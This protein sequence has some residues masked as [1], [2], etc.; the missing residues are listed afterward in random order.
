MVNSQK[1]T[2]GRFS[3]D[4]NKMSKKWRQDGQKVYKTKN[5]CSIFMI[6]VNYLD[7]I[8]TIIIPKFQTLVTSITGKLLYVIGKKKPVLH[9]DCGVSL[10]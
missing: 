9:G 4:L 7:N 1:C 10:Q 8:I 2:Y 3:G 5:I 6:L